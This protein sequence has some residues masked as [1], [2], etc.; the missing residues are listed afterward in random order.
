MTSHITKISVALLLALGA[1]RAEAQL[2][3]DLEGG[4]ASP[5]Y[6]DVRIPGDAGDLFSLTRELEADGTIYTRARLGGQVAPRHHLSVL[7]APLQIASSGTLD[8]D[9]LFENTTF[10]A[11]TPLY[12]RY[13]FNSYR[14]TWRYTVHSTDRITVGLGL[15]GKVRDAQIAASDGERTERNTDLGVVPLVNLHFDWRT[16]ARTGLLLDG[17]ALAAPQG[18][19]VDMMAAA[20]WEPVERLRLRLGYRILEGG[21]DNDAVY[22]FA[23]FHYVVTGVTFRF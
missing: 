8:R 15:T 11:G 10:A 4:L 2:T 12:T 14:L 20:W 13:K 6:N 1:T 17:D 22:T 21:A 23:L 16:T 18:R 9:I 5:G 7:W 19:A 3:L